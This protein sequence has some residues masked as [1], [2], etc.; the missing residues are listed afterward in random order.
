MQS[1]VNIA[2]IVLFSVIFAGLQALLEVAG[3]IP[4]HKTIPVTD[5]SRL[6]ASLALSTIWEDLFQE[7]EQK[8]FKECVDTWFT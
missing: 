7:T 6:H 2:I 1:P 4:E 3:T 5:N 8:A